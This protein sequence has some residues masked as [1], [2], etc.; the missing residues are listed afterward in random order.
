MDLYFKGNYNEDINIFFK[1]LKLILKSV[2]KLVGKITKMIL[3]KKEEDLAHK[4]Q[5]IYEGTA[6]KIRGQSEWLNTQYLRA[7]SQA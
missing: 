5:C 6:I 3:K 7:Q 2:G 1:K 4:Y